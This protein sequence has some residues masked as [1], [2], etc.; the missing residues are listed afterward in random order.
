MA[1]QPREECS[2]GDAVFAQE[3]CPLCNFYGEL[4]LW[5]D[6]NGCRDSRHFFFVKRRALSAVRVKFKF[7]RMA[8][9]GFV[10]SPD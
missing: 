7:Y 4:H 5:Q 6:I 2:G 10:A 1:I 9:R 8:P 3:Q